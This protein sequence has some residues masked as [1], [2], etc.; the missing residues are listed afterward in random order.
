MTPLVVLSDTQV[1]R[2]K[3]AIRSENELAIWVA[4]WL[5][6]LNMFTDAQI[7]DIIKFVLPHLEK[8]EDSGPRYKT[9]LVVCDGR[10]VT[11]TGLQMILD[12]ETSEYLTELY[13]YAVTHIACDIG[14]L[15]RRMIHRQGRSNGKTESSKQPAG[16]AY[17][18]S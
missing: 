3:K 6:H 14:A 18:A 1:L 10:F 13:D 17:Q 12:V 8:F 15:R 2:L 4:D 11:Y 9:T 5:A 16:D 7:Y